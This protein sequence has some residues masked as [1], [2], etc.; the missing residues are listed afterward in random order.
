MLRTTLRND[1]RHLHQ[2]CV[3][4]PTRF[5]DSPISP[6]SS[7]VQ[8]LKKVNKSSNTNTNT[9]NSNSNSNS[10]DVGAACGGNSSNS[11]SANE[12]SEKL[13]LPITPKIQ[14]VKSCD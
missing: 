3:T 2:N 6:S 14:I 8:H 11:Q 10:A 4:E 12:N 13:L 1:S 5:E 7:R 9:N